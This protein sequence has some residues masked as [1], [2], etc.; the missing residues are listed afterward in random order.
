[1]TGSENV[2]EVND[3]YVSNG[4]TDIV[5]NGNFSLKK[6]EFL[7]I[8]GESGCGKSTFMRMMVQL[9]KPTSGKIFFKE[10]DKRYHLVTRNICFCIMN[11]TP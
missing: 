3:L 4:G 2:L 6:G 7:G 9:E 10:K 5:R 1:M 8:A 11:T